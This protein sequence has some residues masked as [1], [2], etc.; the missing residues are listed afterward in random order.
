MILKWIF[1][2]FNEKDEQMKT[3]VLNGC[4]IV[5]DKDGDFVDACSAR[6]PA[7]TLDAVVERVKF[8]HP[9]NAPFRIIKWTGYEFVEV[10]PVS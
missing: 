9:E 8:T 4:Y 1:N 10:T 2:V 7:N 3:K 6:M 5:V